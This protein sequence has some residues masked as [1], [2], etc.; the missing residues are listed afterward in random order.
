MKI[1]LIYYLLKPV[2]PLLVTELYSAHMSVK[3]TIF[4]VCFFLFTE[5][6]RNFIDFFRKTKG[7]NAEIEGIL[8]TEIGAYY[9][10]NVPVVPI[11]G[12][13]FIRAK[14]AKNVVVE[15]KPGTTIKYGILYE[16]YLPSF[17]KSSVFSYSRRL[18]PFLHN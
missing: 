5:F 18:T 4:M 13:K 6:P 11:P 10:T 1:I 9:D 3:F 12:N 14:I 15:P 8:G 17:S 7:V 2:I 16:T